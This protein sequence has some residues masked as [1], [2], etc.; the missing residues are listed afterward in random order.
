MFWVDKAKAEPFRAR[1][2]ND[3]CNAALQ[4]GIQCYQMAQLVLFGRFLRPLGVFSWDKFPIGH[5]SNFWR[6]FQLVA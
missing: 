4:L 6:I 2:I 1:V 5:L 3:W